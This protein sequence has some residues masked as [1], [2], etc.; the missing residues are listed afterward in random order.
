MK[1]VKIVA[2]V[3]LGLAAAAG[4]AYGVVKFTEAFKKKYMKIEEG[5]P[6]AEIATPETVTE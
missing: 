5:D 6:V 1:T 2:G 3:V 4:A